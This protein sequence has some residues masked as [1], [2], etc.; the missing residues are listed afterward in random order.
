MKTVTVSLSESAIRRY[1]KDPEVRELRDP[2]Y[3]LRLRFHAGRTGGSWYLVRYESGQAV[4]QRLGKYPQIAPGTVIEHVA[5]QV[6]GGAVFSAGKSAALGEFERVGDVLRW[7]Y[8]RSQ[9]DRTRSDKFL[10]SEL[11]Y[12]RRHL[13]PALDLLPL[14]E[15]SRQVLDKLVV[16]PLQTR[17]KPKTIKQVFSVLRRAFKCA[18]QL[19]MITGN[20]LADIKFSDFMRVQNLPKTGKIRADHV[21]ELFVRL[22]DCP[23]PHRA[24][25]LLMLLFGTRIGET[26]KARW[27][28]FDRANGFWHIPACNTKTRVPHRL[29]VSDYAWS[30]INLYR[31]AQHDGGYHGP[32][33]FPSARA[34]SPLSPVE[35]NSVIQAV[36]KRQWTA[37]DLRKLARTVWADMGIDYLVAEG[38]LNHA[39][40]ELNSAYIHTDNQKQKRDAIQSYHL[41]L[42]N[43]SEKIPPNQDRTKTEISSQKPL[44]TNY[45]APSRPSL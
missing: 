11:S 45:H 4:W 42:E 23:W 43:Q 10:I 6:A 29:P 17:L 20:P 34:R 27:S 41:W 5:G 13:L 32:F 7:Y 24:L 9:I 30:L 33:L 18:E 38:L 26:R 44:D 37:H 3:P 39:K 40:G 15:V 31:Q 1:Q 14:A 19:H 16:W 28:D 21:P 12:L 22:D 36:S 2:R 8:D 35:A 25:V